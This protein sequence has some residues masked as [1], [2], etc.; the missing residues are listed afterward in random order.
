MRKFDSKGRKWAEGGIC[1]EEKVVS[2][3]RIG[4]KGWN[5]FGEG[6]MGPNE[7]DLLQRGGKDLRGKTLITKV[8]AR[9]PLTLRNGLPYQDPDVLVV[10]QEWSMFPGSYLVSRPSRVYTISNIMGKPTHHKLSSKD[11]IIVPNLYI[12]S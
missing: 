2:K 11:I 1:L 3:E 6:G 4:S 10:C 8:E 7:R 9:S 12:M 5:W